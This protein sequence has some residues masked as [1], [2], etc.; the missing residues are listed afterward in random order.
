M[1]EKQQ[2]RP[3]AYPLRFF[4]WF[5]HPD[6][7]EDI[8]GDLTERFEKRVEEVGTRK[9]RLLFLKDVITLFRPALMR[10]FQLF[11]PLISNFMFRNNLKLAWRNLLK[12]KF[13]SMI[14]IGGLA[15]GILVLMLIGLWIYDEIS[16]NRQFA[17]SERIAAVM[18]NQTFNGHVETGNSQAMQLEPVLRE[19]YGDFFEYVAT[20]T[21]PRNVLLTVNNEKVDKTCIYVGPDFA[22]MLDLNMLKGKRSAMEDP[23]SVLISAST[24][25][26][27][28]GNEEP[29]GKGIM[30]N[31]EIPVT[32]GGVYEDLPANS[33]FGFLDFLAP[34]ELEVQTANLKERVGWGNSWFRV[35]VQIAGN[36]SME[37]VSQ[38]IAKAK[39][40]N[41]EKEWAEKSK[42]EIFLHPMPKWH[43][44]ERFEN[45]VN[46]GGRIEYVRMFGIIGVFVLLLA[47]INFMNLST[48]R[49]EKRAR[50]VGIRKT[51]GSLR[52]QL[53]SQFFSEALL[54]TFFGFGLALLLALI[55]LPQFN[56]IAGKEIGMPWSSP[57]FWLAGLVFTLF[58][59]FVAGSYPSFYLS[60]FKPVKVLKGTFRTGRLAA[61]PR[62]VL[63][64]VQFTVSISLI[65]CTIF[66]FRQ[67][68]FAK[69]RPIGYNRDNLIR[70]PIKS[71]EIIT[72]FRALR[73]DLLNTGYVEEM[74]GTDSPVTSTGTTNGGFTWEGMDPS[75]SNDFT[76]LRVTYEFGDMVDWEILEGRDFSR[77]FATDSLAFILNEAAVEYMGVENPVGMYLERGDSK[78][79]IVGV[80]K[81][82]VTQSPYAPVRQTI[83]M[84]HESWL[85][86]INIKLKPESRPR[87]ALAEIETI[88][89]KYDPLNP[90]EYHFA[91][92]EYAQKFQNEERVG[93]LATF[94]AVL[95]VFISC[96]GLFGL[97]SYMAEQRIKE[98]GIRKVLGASVTNLWQ[99]LSKDFILLIIISCL[100]AAPIAYFLM[101]SW[102]EDYDYRTELSW[103]VFA[104]VG[105]LAIIITLLTVSYQALRAALMNPVQSIKS[106]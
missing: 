8:E 55:L 21:Y 19:T 35:Y 1:K 16:F 54:V 92:E 14:N 18:Q 48:A 67:I 42:P 13:F 68:Q 38:Q 49:S 36:T 43:L 57:W 62:K 4:R 72:H 87:E 89:N 75:L 95:A 106:E 76:S 91:D 20:A 64:V 52:L 73:T 99:L 47:C 96:L 32:V 41:V 105:L 100:L 40:N 103:W 83:F 15:A 78:H 86:Q 74:A 3:P 7:V 60:A 5:C 17:N 84:L 82:L 59:A 23:H 97:A 39:Y 101:K 12:N 27:L 28:F 70:V 31:H 102:L 80:V 2:A 45:G 30:I 44:Y 6:F 50:E 33:S 22:E 56:E 90:F 61:V 24:A 88:F 104:V 69:D 29:L 94:F 79:P 46:T 58:T 9:A 25:E 77:D 53:I 63:V 37:Q 93:K 51:L 11:Y 85:N 34:F 26:S 65:I 71:D 98:I 81:N 10:P 66:I